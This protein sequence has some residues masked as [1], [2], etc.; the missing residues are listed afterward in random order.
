MSIVESLRA[1]FDR[2]LEL[3]GR[4]NADYA[5]ADDPFRNFRGSVTVG[6]PVERAMLVRL[7]DKINRISNLLDKE[8]AVVGESL[9]D[10]IED[11]INYLALLKAFREKQ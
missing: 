8:P 2:C 6:V 7:M 11:A 10:S 5:G 3:A 4:K 9:D 1:T